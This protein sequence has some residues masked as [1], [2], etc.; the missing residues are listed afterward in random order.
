M[1]TEILKN[2]LICLRKE[3]NYT[4]KDLADKLN[5]SD[6]VISKWERGESVPDLEA[7]KIISRF[8]NLTMDELVSA[9][10]SAKEKNGTKSNKIEHRVLNGP[11]KLL[12]S[13]IWFFLSI[14]AI[15][16]GYA[17]IKG[18]FFAFLFANIGFIIYFVIYSW[19]LQ[20]VVFIA[21]YRGHEIKVITNIW[22]VEMYIDGILVDEV[23]NALKPNVRLTGRVEEERVKANISILLN[24]KLSLFF[25]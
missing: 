12:K 25:E 14:Y 13:S 22:K 2:N 24:V 10:L 9:N 1:D 15:F 21:N 5:Y 23:Y 19:L 11:S 17:I 3:N 20:K 6:K 16:I 4:Q 7:L 8:Y 18:D